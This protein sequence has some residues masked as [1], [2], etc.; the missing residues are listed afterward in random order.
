MTFTSLETAVL[1]LL[2]RTEGG[3]L[4]R[5]QREALA[6][7]LATAVVVD[8]DNTGHGFYT[9]FEVDRSAA[10][11]LVGVSMMDAPTIPME[12]LGEGNSLGF[13]FW[14]ADGYE[15]TLEGFQYG[16]LAGQTVDLNDYDL[17]EP[18]SLHLECP[19]LRRHCNSAKMPSSSPSPPRAS[20]ADRHPNA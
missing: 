9:K 8:R 5:E 16:D 17:Y 19:L 6:R 1:R 3:Q 20:H 15:W 2:C 18:Q 14:A 13:I 10:D 11:R 12:G 7:Q 4:G